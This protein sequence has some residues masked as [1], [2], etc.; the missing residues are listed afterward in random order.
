MWKARRSRNRDSAGQSLVEMALALPVLLLMF[1]GLIELG[2]LLRAHLVVVNANREAARFASRGTFTNEEIAYRAMT[3]FAGQLPAQLDGANANTQIIITHFHIPAEDTGPG[4]GKFYTPFI[5]GTLGLDSRIDPATYLRDLEQ[6]HDSFNEKLVKSQPDAV[7]TTQD[8]VLVE[9]YYYH[10]EILHA[11]I[12]EWL[13]P[14]PMVV[15]SH[16]L[17]RVGAGR[18]S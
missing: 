18:V 7:R 9:I 16:T 5:T 14:D 2:L 10:Y 17:M 15:Y 12:V 3:S 11:P 6:E 8:I 4:D 13:F 1:L